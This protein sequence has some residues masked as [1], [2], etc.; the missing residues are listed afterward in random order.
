MNAMNSGR[1]LK[2]DNLEEVNVEQGLLLVIQAVLHL[3][4]AWMVRSV[5]VEYHA[6]FPK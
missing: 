5:Q 1:L 3:M 2:R 4:E 6:R